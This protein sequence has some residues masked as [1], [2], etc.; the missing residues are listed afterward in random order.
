MATNKKKRGLKMK[1]KIKALTIQAM[2][3][4]N[5][6]IRDLF[7]L[8]QSEIAKREKEL[9]RDL[10]DEEVIAVLNK[11]KKQLN[12]TMSFY[13]E[14]T[15]EKAIAAVTEIKEKIIT[16]EGLLP[17][18]LSE[19][20]VRAEIDKLFASNEFGNMG[21]AMKTILATDL[22]TKADKGLISRLVKEKFNK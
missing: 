15:S 21:V 16:I 11:E 3:E 6:L 9:K 22:S 12:E 18:Q 20:E 13:K 1:E 17:K 8:V 14:D 7:R 4:K 5:I 10:T 2:K 19:E